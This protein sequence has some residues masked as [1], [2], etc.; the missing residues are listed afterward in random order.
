[1]EWDGVPESMFRNV[2]H[3]ANVKVYSYILDCISP[4]QIEISVLYK[5]MMKLTQLKKKE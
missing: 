1:M 4:P 3:S 2:K 5:F